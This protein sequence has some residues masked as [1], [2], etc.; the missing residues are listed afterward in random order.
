MCDIDAAKKGDG[1]LAY[2]EWVV[3]HILLCAGSWQD[4]THK[5][6]ENASNTDVRGKH[7]CVMNARYHCDNRDG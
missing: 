1:L 7:H 2:G 5:N 3:S 4:L 6:K